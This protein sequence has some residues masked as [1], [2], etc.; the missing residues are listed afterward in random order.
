MVHDQFIEIQQNGEVLPT[1]KFLY[2]YE[3][4]DWKSVQVP[5][6]ALKLTCTYLD[7]YLWEAQTKKGVKSSEIEETM[8]SIILLKSA[9]VCSFGNEFYTNNLE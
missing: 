3:L 4:N 7:K 6:L 8:L 2:N 1:E 5:R 9:T